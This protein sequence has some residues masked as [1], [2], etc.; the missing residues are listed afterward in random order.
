MKQTG[1][2]GRQIALALSDFYFLTLGKDISKNNILYYV[3][4]KSLF[5]DHSPAP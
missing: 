2:I 4:Y 1:G 3:K 5:H